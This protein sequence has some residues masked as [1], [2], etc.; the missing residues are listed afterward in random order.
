MF[1][2]KAEGALSSQ[3]MRD[4]LTAI[5]IDYNKSTSFL[6]FSIYIFKIKNWPYVAEVRRCACG[7]LVG[8]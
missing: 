2:E 7:W 6:E 1:L 4:A 3:Q 8:A 5:D